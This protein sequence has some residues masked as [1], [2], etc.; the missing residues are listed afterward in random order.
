MIT[1]HIDLNRSTNMNYFIYTSRSIFFIKSSITRLCSSR[2]FFLSDNKLLM[3]E[4]RVSRCLSETYAPTIFAVSRPVSRRWR[5]D[6]WN[7]STSVAVARASCTVPG[8]VWNAFQRISV[9]ASASTKWSFAR[10]SQTDRCFWICL[11]DE[12]LDRLCKLCLVY[13]SW[14]RS[15]YGVLPKR[16]KN[17]LF[18]RR[19]PK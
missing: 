2:S 3:D 13:G 6:I 4:S 11:P 9:S 12:S 5:S 17:S 7:A 14:A 15:M 16:N 18:F 10:T 1:L 8:L 19:L